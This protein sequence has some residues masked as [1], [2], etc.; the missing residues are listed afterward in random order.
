M[1]GLT[2]SGKRLKTYID[3]V[4]RLEEEKQQIADDI[5]EVYSEAKSDGFDVKIMKKVVSIR[6][7]DDN[8]RMEEE[9]LLSVY[10]SSI[11]ME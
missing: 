8:D 2:E 9:Q 11:G 6:K 7:K 4:E 1:T 3:R 10:K 5:K